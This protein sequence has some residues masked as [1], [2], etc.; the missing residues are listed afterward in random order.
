MGSLLAYQYVLC[1]T[2]WHFPTLKAQILTAEA[3]QMFSLSRVESWDPFVRLQ[4]GDSILLRTAGLT[5]LTVNQLPNPLEKQ[6]LKRG[7]CTGK[8]KPPE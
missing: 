2:F 1:Y 5:C 3:L 6:G 7:Y 4:P 8:V